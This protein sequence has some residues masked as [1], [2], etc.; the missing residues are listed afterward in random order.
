MNLIMSKLKELGYLL[1]MK[2]NNSY[3]SSYGKTILLIIII[4]GLLGVSITISW[5]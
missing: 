4:G 2:K 5:L 1:K 3:L